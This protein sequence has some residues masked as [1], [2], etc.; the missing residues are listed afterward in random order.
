MQSRKGVRVRGEDEG[1]YTGRTTFLIRQ[2]PYSPFQSSAFI[3]CILHI[4]ICIVFLFL[5]LLPCFLLLQ[6]SMVCIACTR[7]VLIFGGDFFFLNCTS[8]GTNVH[9]GTLG[10]LKANATENKRYLDL[11]SC[12]KLQRKFVKF[13]PFL[14]PSL[15]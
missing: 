2:Q 15:R 9:S 7:R 14:S 3:W 12:L 13:F 10:T 11:P 4:S 8:R 1:Y 5:S 6:G